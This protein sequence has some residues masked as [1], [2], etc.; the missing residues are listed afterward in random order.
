MKTIRVPSN[1]MEA[2]VGL[3]CYLTM[4]GV[5]FTVKLVGNEWVIDPQGTPESLRRLGFGE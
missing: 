3:C 2:L 4:Q 1:N 5:R